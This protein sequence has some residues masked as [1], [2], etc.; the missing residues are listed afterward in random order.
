MGYRLVCGVFL[1]V[2]ACLIGFEKR[3]RLYVRLRSLEMLRDYFRS[4]RGYISHVGMSLDDIAYEIDKGMSRSN[5]SQIIRE[6][7]HHNGFSTAFADAVHTL[8]NSLCITADD[9]ALLCSFAERIGGLD[10]DGAVETLQLA[11]EQLISLIDSV[12]TK[13]ETD[14]KIY[15]AFGLSCGIVAALMLL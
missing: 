13:C 6:K 12:K 11:D 9:Q 1:V 3:S 5:F 4:V 15:V 7:T 8:K 14:G 2:C 10:R